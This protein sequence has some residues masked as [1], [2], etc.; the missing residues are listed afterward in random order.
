MAEFQPCKVEVSRGSPVLAICPC[1][2]GNKSVGE[3]K[4]FAKA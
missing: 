3:S 4:V 1:A 2:K